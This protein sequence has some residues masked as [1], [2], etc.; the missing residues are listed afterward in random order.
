MKQL[1]LAEMLK[2]EG[3][4]EI[5]NMAETMNVKVTSAAVMVFCCFVIFKIRLLALEGQ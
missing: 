4:T 5:R 3:Y 2:E 1:L